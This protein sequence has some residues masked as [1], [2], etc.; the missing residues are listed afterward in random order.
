MRVARAGRLRT[1]KALPSWLSS[2]RT[3]CEMA[4]DV[5]CSRSAACSKLPVSTTARNASVCLGFRFMVRA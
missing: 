3:R 4:G 1:I 5:R 2:A